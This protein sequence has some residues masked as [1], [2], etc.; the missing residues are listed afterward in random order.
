M[1]N[2]CRWQQK[3]EFRTSCKMSD[4]FAGFEQNLGF[5]DRRS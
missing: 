5:L 1:A 3:P 2:L 4:I